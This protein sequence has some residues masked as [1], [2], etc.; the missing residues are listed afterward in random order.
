MFAESAKNGIAFL[1]DCLLEGRPAEGVGFCLADHLAITPV[2]DG[3]SVADPSTHVSCRLNAAASLILSYCTGDH[4][5]RGIADQVLPFLKSEETRSDPYLLLIN[6]LWHLRALNLIRIV[7]PAAPTPSST[8]L[9]TPLRE[10]HL[11]LTKRCPLRCVHCCI[12]HDRRREMTTRQILDLLSQFQYLGLPKVSFTGGE[13]LLRGD[14]FEIAAEARALGLT[15]DLA[16]SGVTLDRDLA[17]RIARLLPLRVN[18]SVYSSDPDVHD[19]ITGVPG[20]WQRSLAAIR[21]LTDWGVPVTIKCMVMSPN[22]SSYA[23]VAELAEELGQSYAFD[24]GITCRLDG[25]RDPLKYRITPEQLREFAQTQFWHEV[26]CRE[27]PL[28]E[29]PCHAGAGRCAV[30]A[31]GDVYPCVLFPL[32]V[33]SVIEQPL[34]KILNGPAMREIRRLTIREMGGYA[35]CDNRR[36]CTPCPGLAFLEQGDYRLSPQ[37]CCTMAQAQRPARAEHSFREEGDHAAY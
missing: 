33:G 32:A 29:R 5:L 12:A 4:T 34:R 14:F 26:D 27:M 9:D 7:S 1:E 17:T 37:W 22:F 21:L 28:T 11:F 8:R 20:S 31:K 18:I 6:T 19:Q 16:T 13:P 2:E 30:D 23:G 3:L 25:S 24:P 10:V 15:F 35:A 36:H